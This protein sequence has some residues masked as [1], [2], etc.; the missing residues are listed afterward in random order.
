MHGVSG[1]LTRIVAI[2]VVS[3]TAVAGVSLVGALPA[4]ASGGPTI[5][6]GFAGYTPGTTSPPSQFDALTLV[7]GGAAS[8]N[9]ASLTIVTQPASGTAT[10]AP[11]STNGIITYTPASGTTGTQTLTFAYCTPGNTYPS[12]GN[13][14]TATISYAA[15]VGEYMGAN[16]ANITGVI[17][18]VE[19]A[20]SLPPTA[21]QGSAVTA[22]IAPVP[23]SVPSS[24]SGVTVN[25][26]SQ[27]SVVMPVPKGLTYVPG[28]ITVTGGD[29]TTSGHYTAT[30]CTGPVANACTAQIASGNYKTVY[31]YIETFL[32]PG[33]TISGGSNVTLPT[34]TAQ[35]TATGDV[36]TVQSLV[37]TEFVLVTSV[38]I[39]GTATFDGYPSCSAC[40]SG[41]NPTYQTP[42]PLASTTITSATAH[43]VTVTGV[44]PSTGP[45]AGGT[46]VTLS[47]TD[48]SG[49]TAVDFGSTPATISA[50]SDTALTATAPPGTGTVDVTVTT[51]DGTSATSSADRYTYTVVVPPPAVT[52]VSPATGP[53]GGGTSVT[54]TGTN[55]SGATAVDFG[56]TPGTI[57]AD[58]S[59][60]VTATSPAGAGTVDVTVVTPSGVSAPVAA[61]QFSFG[62]QVLTHLSSWTD[63]QACGISATTT[64]PAL[65]TEVVATLVGGSG[66]GGGGAASSDSGGSGGPGSTVAGTYPVA[67]GSALTATSGCNGATAPHGSGVVS[68]GGTGGAGYSNG[69][70]G[71]Q[72][73]YCA[74]I[75]ALGACIGTGGADG[76]GG[77]GGG[78]SALCVGTSC[79][80]GSTPLVVAAGAGGG[81]ESMCA[82]S[83]GGGGGT[84]GGGSSTASTDGTG[85]GPSG[86]GGG[87]G[88]TSGDVGGTGGVNDSTGSA[89]GGAGGGGSVSVSFGDSAGN[90][91]GGGGYVG[92]LG[93][94]STAGV[95]CGAGGGG[96][97]GSSWSVIGSN[98]TFGT[99]TAGPSIVLS[100][101][102]F[103]GAKPAVTTQPAGI[104]VVAGQTATFTA[105]G[106]GNPSPLVQ[107]EVSSDGG[108]TF[109]PIVGANSTTLSVVTTASDDQYRYE[110]VLANSLGSATS[111]PATLTVQTV[112]QVTGQPTGAV[113]NTGLPAS[114]TAAAS[115]NPTPTVTWQVSTDGGTTFTDVPGAT[116]G[117]YTFTTAAGESGN[118]YQAVFS[119]AAGSA[120]SNPATL[121]LD[122][123]PVVGINPTPVTV[124]AGHSASFT[125]SASAVPSPTVQWQVSTDGGSTFTAIG[126]ATAG[127]YSLVT[128]LTQNGDQYRAAFTNPVGTVYSSA[129][130][131]TVDP[132]PPL[133]ITTTSLPAGQVYSSTHKVKYS[134][135]LAATSGNPPYQWKVT[136]GSLP[137]GLKLSKTK[138]TISGKASF[139][140]SFTFTVEVLDK[141]GPGPLHLQNTATAQFT[142]VIA[143]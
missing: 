94:S 105:A 15:S 13:C 21:V 29:A 52:G 1:R 72:G 107:W 98:P 140:G 73:Y 20:V 35:F 64:V 48:L 38:Q 135:T 44:T 109:S 12:A 27:F 122:T 134:A 90:G 5:A 126:G 133:S 118:E 142:V 123:L 26:A 125:A 106:T 138:G 62:S 18:E 113:V 11:T 102:G 45:P 129:A 28:S 143:P 7:S 88:D 53:V 14:T 34:V 56:S 77:G 111:S 23:T 92:G 78:S 128:A 9:T 4:V 24:E 60:S 97:G 132:V 63:P 54:V 19:T 58:S 67:P 87:Q 104:T 30:Y 130:L 10:A 103:V 68:T 3:L 124:I 74:G 116:S 2:G 43:T 17:Q 127:T 47:G 121:T 115:G 139:A 40:A 57:T 69:G 66:G 59:S 101:Y 22:A 65:A 110:A 141:K 91:G 108:T 31:P 136:A 70:G 25:G 82:G 46:S 33:T 75:N 83:N 49:A 36:G 117:T 112:P 131:L 84:A 119:N 114:F 16:V 99:S 76:S 86:T 81:G 96:G 8:V 93:S 71:G 80:V 32:N 39:I 50:D 79:Q 37:F 51:P 6:N 100:Y 120:T 42:S 95:D 55:L 85:A 61:D 89:G 137:N 41:N